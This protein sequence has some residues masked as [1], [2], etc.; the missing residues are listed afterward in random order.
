MYMLINC[1]ALS[2]RIL[3]RVLIMFSREASCS[4]VVSK[5][6]YVNISKCCYLC[7]GARN[8]VTLYRHQNQLQYKPQCS[9]QDPELCP[10]TAVN[11]KDPD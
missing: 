6:W 5:V 3:K 11:S 1:Y 7:T 9:R 8:N 4:N 10:S 2:V